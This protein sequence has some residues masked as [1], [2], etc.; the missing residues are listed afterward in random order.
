MPNP[1]AWIRSSS[2]S[3]RL[4]FR[5]NVKRDLVAGELLTSGCARGD[6]VSLDLGYI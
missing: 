5:R 1:R 2:D 4:R 6:D 3:Q